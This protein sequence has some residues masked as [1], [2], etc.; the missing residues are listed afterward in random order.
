MPIIFCCV[1]PI[2]SECICNTVQTSAKINVTCSTAAVASNTY[3]II[4]NR[5]VT[6]VAGEL[7]LAIRSELVVFSH[8]VVDKM[9]VLVGGLPFRMP[10]RQY[11]SGAIS[12]L[13]SPF[14]CGPFL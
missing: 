1:L 10:V 3:V 5:R 2:V 6:N 9:I 7:Q 13:R 12:Y 14:H 4:D 11:F 8:T